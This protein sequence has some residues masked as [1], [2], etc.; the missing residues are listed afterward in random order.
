MTLLLVAI[1][2]PATATSDVPIE[3]TVMGEHGPPDFEDEDC[4]AAGYAWRF[5]SAGV[6]Q[7]SHLGRVEYELTQCTVPGPEGFVSVGT[8]TF[9]AANDDE[10]WI[11]HTMF[12]Q[13]I[14]EFPVAEGFTFEGEWTA[15]G[16]TGRFAH[17]TGAGTLHGFGDIPGGEALFGLPDGLAQFNFSGR[18]AYDASDRSGV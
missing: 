16:G 11:E 3:G 8:V 6:G 13:L 2:T 7:M 12:S 9:I 4:L 18:I 17:A 5:P 15:V 14:G 1:A 10:L